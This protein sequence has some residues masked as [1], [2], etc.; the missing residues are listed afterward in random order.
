MLQE[1]AKDFNIRLTKKYVKPKRSH[2]D[3]GNFNSLIKKTQMEAP[4]KGKKKF[5]HFYFGEERLNL[6]S[7]SY[8]RYEKIKPAKKM[9]LDERNQFLNSSI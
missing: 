4:I 1:C 7:D 9:F 8:G 2:S 3:C 5:I 6:F